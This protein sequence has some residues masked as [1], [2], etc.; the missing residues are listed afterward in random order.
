MG[1]DNEDYDVIDIEDLEADLSDFYGDGTDNTFEATMTMKMVAAPS[2][3]VMHMSEN[4][5][6]W[7][8][9]AHMVEFD[10]LKEEAASLRARLADIKQHGAAAP[11]ELETEFMR[12]KKLAEYLKARIH[13]T[14]DTSKRDNKVFQHQVG[15]LIGWLPEYVSPDHPVARMKRA[16]GPGR[17]VLRAETVRAPGK[18]VQSFYFLEEVNAVDKTHKL[19]LLGYHMGTD[20]ADFT[21]TLEDLSENTRVDV[22]LAKDIPTIMAAC[23]NEIFADE[24]IRFTD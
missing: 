15:S 23:Y 10:A 14:E 18:P 22:S 9:E 5:L 20:P 19:A 6:K 24:T 12:T 1:S 17:R 13:D 3:I 11:V 16:S 2:Y 21:E 8:H 7:A 4:P